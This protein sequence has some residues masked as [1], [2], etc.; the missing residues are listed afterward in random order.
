METPRIVIAAASSGC[1]KTTIVTGILSALKNRGLKVQPYKIGPD[2][3]DPGFHSRASGVQSRN[4][5]SWLV[6]AKKLRDMF[7]ESS[8]KFDLAIIEGVMGLFDGGSNGVSSTAEIAKLLDSPVI[9]ILD[10]KSQG[11]S[12]AATALGFKNFDPDLKFAGVILNRIGSENHRRMIEESLAKIGIQ[13]FGAIRRDESLKLPER[14]LGLTPTTESAALDESIAKISAAIESQ[15]NLDK[16]LEVSKI[17]LEPQIDDFSRRP[18]IA[19]ARD[20]VFSFYYPE[21][22]AILE[23]LGA[24][25]I[26]FSPLHDKILPEC[27]GLIIGGGF[28]EMFAEDLEKNSSM[29]NSIYQAAQNSMPILAECG[30]FMYLSKSIQDFNG[31]I[32]EMCGV[33]ESKV[34]MESKLQMVGYVEARLNRDCILGKAGEIFHAHEFHF[35][36]EIDSQDES[37][38]ECTRLRNDQKYSAGRIKFNS[39]GSY[40]HFHFA[41]AESMA[42]NFVDACRRR[43]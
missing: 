11:S 15:L 16:I 31:K 20:E 27:E 13:S 9:L 36:R 22:L 29:R 21:S 25:L 42:R 3:I 23:N 30:G 32:F 8:Q 41:G 4:L 33:F 40:L 7:L 2:Y 5:D 10:V 34:E 35:S 17:S 43:M 19:I 39:I 1:G 38:F 24:K 37:I 26:Y 12:A 18:R 6:P 14:H 28:P